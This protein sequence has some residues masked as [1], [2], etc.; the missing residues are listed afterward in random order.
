MKYLLSEYAISNA[1]NMFIL[2]NS[3][4][5]RCR[6]WCVTPLIDRCVSLLLVLRHD[7]N[8]TTVIHITYIVSKNTYLGVCITLQTFCDALCLLKL[9]NAEQVIWCTI[10]VLDCY[11]NCIVRKDNRKNDT[12]IST[13]Q[14]KLMYYMTPLHII[15]YI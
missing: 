4:T 11:I 9:E 10:L 3:A 8:F 15:S 7:V 13:N 6:V 12:F 14:H 1:A 5:L 2:N